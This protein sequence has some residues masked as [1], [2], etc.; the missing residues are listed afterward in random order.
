MGIS[1]VTKRRVHWS[2]GWILNTVCRSRVLNGGANAARI[3]TNGPPDAVSYDG[4]V[5]RLALIVIAAFMSQ[6]C[7]VLTINPSHDRESLLWEPALIGDWHNADD[8]STLKIER[9]EWQSYRIE[10]VH[11]IETGRL[12]GYLTRIGKATYLDVMPAR[13]QDHGSFL[14]P[15]HAT[16]R[17]ALEGDRLELTALSYDWFFDRLKKRTLVP[18]LTVA[19]DEKENALI[20]NP[21]KEIRG[22]LAKQAPTGQAFGASAVFTRKPGA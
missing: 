10:Y 9:A 4:G 12:T 3:G 15:V 14:V 2:I 21:T 16:L 1:R 5:I 6:A 17:V 18:G 19:L 7:L 8:N 20:V 11:P 22:W 13:G